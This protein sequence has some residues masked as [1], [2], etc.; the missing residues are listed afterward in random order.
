VRIFTCHVFSE[1]GLPPQISHIFAADAERAK[2]LAQLELQRSDAI[3]VE[4]WEGQ[5]LLWSEPPGEEF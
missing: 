5:S 1:H 4:L 3:A 2:E